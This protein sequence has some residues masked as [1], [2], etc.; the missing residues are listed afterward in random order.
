MLA[1]GDLPPELAGQDEPDR[2]HD[3][4]RREPQRRAPLLQP[5]LLLRGG[6]ERPR[7]QAPPARRQR[8]RARPRHPHLRLPRALLPEGPRG[9]RPVRAPS[10]E[11]RPGG[12]RGGRPA[13]GHACTTPPATAT[14]CCGPTCW[15]SPPASPRRPTTRCCRACCAAP[16]PPTASSWRRIPSCARWTWPTRASSSA[17]W[18]TRRASS[19]RP[20]PR[21]R[22]PSGGPPPSSPRR[23]WRS[24]ARSPRS[25]PTNCV[26]CATCVKVC[27]YGA[28]MINDLEQ[29]RD[30]GRQVHG[31]RQLRGRLPGPD[32]HPAAPG[33]PGAGGHARRTARRMEVSV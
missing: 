25:I 20:S 23:T 11:G 19:T 14:W 15:C 12:G 6:Q 18:P 17:A 32:H 5:R 21:P 22:P 30:P 28:P 27:P 4:V 13:Q 33:R 1:G 24:P 29:G 10:R 7:D 16:S 3:P 26:A 9:G 8:G 31:L 2:R